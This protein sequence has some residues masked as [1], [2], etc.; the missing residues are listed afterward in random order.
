MKFGLE[1][2]AVLNLPFCQF[3]PTKQKKIEDFLAVLIKNIFNLEKKNQL[4]VI[5]RG[6][7][8]KNLG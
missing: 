6:W 2:F 4:K 1:D 7:L 3:K 5:R 8:I